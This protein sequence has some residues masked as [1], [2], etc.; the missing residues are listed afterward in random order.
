MA[1]SYK[2][3]K[4][5]PRPLKPARGN[6]GGATTSASRG[7]RPTLRPPH[8]GGGG[9]GYVLLVV[10]LLLLVGAGSL[11]W[12]A[13]NRI[14]NL[15]GDNNPIATPVPVTGTP[16]PTVDPL[17]TPI[18]ILLLGVDKR[19]GETCVRNDVN[20]VV[21]IDPNHR[22]ATMLSI[23]RDVR[24][25]IPGHGLN[26]INAAYCFGEG[27][28]QGHG[29]L[30]SMRTVANM[31]GLNI[32]HYIEVDFQGFERIIDHL[33]GV[34]V[35]VPFPLLD[36]EYPTEDYRYTR[37]YIPAGLQHMDGRTAL[38][39]ARSRHVD[40]DI[41]RNQRQQQILLAIRDKALRQIK[42]QDLFLGSEY[43]DGL[44]R[45]VGDSFKTDMSLKTLL[46]LAQLAPKI[47]GNQIETYALGW[48]CLYELDG[49]DLGYNSACL[50][51]MV[52][53]MTTSPTRRKLLQEGARVIVLN[54]T[55]WC[56]G[57]AQQVANDLRGYD[58]NVV[59]F[60]NAEGVYTNTLILDSDDHPFT[61]NFLGELLGVEAEHV[62]V[63]ESVS[64]S[65]D[66]VIILGDDYERI[67][68]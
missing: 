23:P 47:D 50:A 35:D 24:V 20:I 34:T 13:Y 5:K 27:D 60:G 12:Q 10:L 38:Q 30:L 25:Q 26:K 37:I 68:E 32:H 39:Y 46:A 58:I 28:E 4:S 43:V 21:H 40:T 17:D 61:R 55:L 56:T 54:G 1:G 67:G 51:G 57:C 64:G 65:A 6:L 31:T 9:V 2:H 49:S 22:F 3:R 33:G 52:D 8:A 11:A 62:Q 63:G 41:G 59:E 36:N 42:L 53:E 7:R 18:N 48:D 45:T 44:L 16:A 29:P 19:E 14:G 66:I 15:I